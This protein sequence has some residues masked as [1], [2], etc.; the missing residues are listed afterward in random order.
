MQS[1]RLRNRRLTILYS[2][3]ALVSLQDPPF[4]SSRSIS[5]LNVIGFSCPVCSLRISLYIV[6]HSTSARVLPGERR[7]RLRDESYRV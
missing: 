5:Q 4:G 7:H 6:R 2:Y 3:A 1:L